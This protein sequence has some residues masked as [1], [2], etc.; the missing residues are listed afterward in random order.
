MRP[1]GCAPA[2]AYGSTAAPGRSR[3]SSDPDLSAPWRPSPRG[4]GC[5]APAR[6]GAVRLTEVEAYE[7]RPI[8]RRTRTGGVTPRN[9]IMFGP[10]GHLYVLLQLWHALAANIICGPDGVASGVLLRAGEVVAVSSWPGPGGGGVAIVI[11]RVPG[12]AHS[13][14]R[15]QRGA[16]GRALLDGGRC[17]WSP[18]LLNRR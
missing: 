7:G 15:S 9:A 12:P 1:C 6:A 8:P 4:A 18:P 16:E 3:C 14:A 11:L 5:G 10:P 17:G 2:I 13:G